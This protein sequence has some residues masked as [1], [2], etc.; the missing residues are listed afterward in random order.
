MVTR[1]VIVVVALIFVCGV[2]FAAVYFGNRLRGDTFKVTKEVY[3]LKVSIFRNKSKISY[4]FKQLVQLFKSKNIFVEY[5]RETL[6]FAIN[7]DGQ[8]DYFF[9]G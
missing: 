6:Q 3:L 5:V 7:S 4:C 2:V 9:S 1:F 8:Y